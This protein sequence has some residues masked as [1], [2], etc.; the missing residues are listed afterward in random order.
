[1]K[2]LL[3]AGVALC[4]FSLLSA[5]KEVRNANGSYYKQ[6]V[7]FRVTEPLSKLVAAHQAVQKFSTPKL[8]ADQ[9][10]PPAKNRNAQYNPKACLSDGA[11]QNYEG[12]KENKAPIL[13]FDGAKGQGYVPL[14]PNG[15]VGSNN[16]VQTIN[17]AFSIF[18]K[19][20]TPILNNADLTVIFGT[21]TCDDGDPVTM[22]DRFAD[23][24]IITE[25]QQNA[26]CSVQ[27]A[28][29]DTMMMAVSVTN[30]PTGSYYMY[31]FCPDNADFADYPKYSIW[32]D[33]YYQTCNCQDDKV[34]V[35]QR[36]SM[37]KGSKNAGFIVIPFN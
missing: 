32:A 31:Y 4:T 8:A 24:W 11:L 10:A 35:Y 34:V 12:S 33:G 17:S 21:F 37:L 22:Y 7:R 3:L 9:S 29:M 27:G 30:D 28:N 36:D 5:Q 2:K 25:F 16:Y 19:S 15:M 20:G 13:S 1:M 18:D 6:C 14:D 26:A 23:R